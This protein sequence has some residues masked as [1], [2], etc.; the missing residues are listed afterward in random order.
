MTALSKGLSA[1]AQTYTSR[2]RLEALERPIFIGQNGHGPYRVP[3]RVI[4]PIKARHYAEYR[5]M[6]SNFGFCAR[7]SMPRVDGVG[8]I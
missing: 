1:R 8:Q 7:V 3:H 6:P 2:D 4:P 5:I